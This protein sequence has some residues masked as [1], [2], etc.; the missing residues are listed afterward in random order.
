MNTE[1]KIIV[2]VALASVFIKVFM[3]A[4]QLYFFVHYL[5]LPKITVCS[6]ITVIVRLHRQGVV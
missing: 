2:S 6:V 3:C 4:C 1:F 5:F